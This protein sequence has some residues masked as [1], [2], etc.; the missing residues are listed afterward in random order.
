MLLPEN[1]FYNTSSPGI[2]MVINRSKAHPGEILLVNAS[3]QFEKGRPKNHL[4]DE[5][6]ERVANSYRSWSAVDAMAT[7]IKT[8]EC[9]RNDYNLSPSRYVSTGGQ[10]EVVPLEEAVVLLQEAEEER[11]E[12]DKQLDAV[13][14][15]LGFEGWR[16]GK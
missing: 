2:V 4:A 15:K 7:V 3:K 1:L 5:H 11:A 13:L 9:A 12:A 6:I 10:E 14:S 8:E 16:D